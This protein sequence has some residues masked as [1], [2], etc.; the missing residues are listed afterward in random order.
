MARYTDSRCKVCRREKMKLYLKG[1]RCHKPSCPFEKRENLKK[2]RRQFTR[3]RRQSEYSLRLREK[4][5]VKMI[6]GVLERQFRNYFERA[7]RKK[8]VTGENLLRF[9]ESRLDNVVFRAGFAASRNAARQIV[10]HKHVMVNGKSVNLPSYQVRPK[11][12]VAIKGKSLVRSFIQEM[13]KKAPKEGGADWL[14]VDMKKGECVFLDYPTKEKM[15][16]PINEQMI[17]ELYSK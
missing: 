5:K 14:Q 10:N 3:R 13:V 12:V 16:L 15:E 1:E 6:Y 2:G 4:Q 7:A 11:D 9:L 17:V 8:G